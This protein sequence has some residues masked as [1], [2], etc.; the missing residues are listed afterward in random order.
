MIGKNNKHYHGLS[1]V[2]HLTNQIAASLDEKGF[3]R[4][5][6]VT[7]MDFRLALKEKGF[8]SKIVSN[9]SVVVLFDVV[10]FKAMIQ[11]LEGVFTSSQLKKVEQFFF[12]NDDGVA[13][14][15]ELYD[16]NMLGGEYTDISVCFVFVVKIA[17]V[18]SLLQIIDAIPKEI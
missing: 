9:F 14:A 1:R 12:N 13:Y 7:G 5:N 6:C 18:K 4:V 2:E 16:K 3:G 8:S 15:A 17:Q 11:R 10:D